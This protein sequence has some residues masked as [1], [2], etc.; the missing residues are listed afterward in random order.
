MALQLENVVLWGRSAREYIGMFA[1]TPQ[2]A[3]RRILDCAAGPIS[4][5]AEM[6]EKG[7][8]VVACDP[9]Y[10]FSAEEIQQR[11]DESLFENDGFK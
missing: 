4:F 1:L 8:Q 10:Q 9:I 2:E 3:N 11:I 6:T 7:T 5:T